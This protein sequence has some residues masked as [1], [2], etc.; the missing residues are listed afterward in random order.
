MPYLGLGTWCIISLQ[1]KKSNTVCNASVCML[2][3]FY[4]FLFVGFRAAD[5]DSYGNNISGSILDG[6]ICSYEINVVICMEI[7]VVMVL[8]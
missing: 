7:Y 8:H 6:D 2:C 4:K 5:P 1:S 3:I